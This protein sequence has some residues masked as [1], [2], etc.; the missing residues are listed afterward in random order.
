MN[1]MADQATG[2]RSPKCLH[3]ADV[4]KAPSRMAKPET[5]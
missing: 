5:N 3:G 1:E 2:E 4:M